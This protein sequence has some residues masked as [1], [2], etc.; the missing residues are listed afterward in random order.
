MHHVWS[1]YPSG[2]AAG[3]AFAP[4]SIELTLKLLEEAKMVRGLRLI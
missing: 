2:F 1:R 4:T 3:C